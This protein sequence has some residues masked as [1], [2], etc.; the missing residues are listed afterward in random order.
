MLLL[1]F[2]YTFYTF[3]PVTLFKLTVSVILH[4][5]QNHNFL[6][7]YCVPDTVSRTSHALTHLIFTIASIDSIELLLY[8]CMHSVNEKTGPHKCRNLLRIIQLILG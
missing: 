4:W 2:L 7:A 6:K 5:S 1:S 3:L 8:Y